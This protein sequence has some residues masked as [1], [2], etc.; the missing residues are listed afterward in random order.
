MM[1]PRICFY[2][3][4]ITECEESRSNAA[5][6]EKAHTVRFFIYQKIKAD[7]FFIQLLINARRSLLG[8]PVA[9]KSALHV[10]IFKFCADG[11][12]FGGAFFAM[13]SFM[14]ALRSAPFMDAE[15]FLHMVRAS[16]RVLAAAAEVETSAS[17]SG[18]AMAKAINTFFI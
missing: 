17:D 12:F 18:K 10:F 5:L 13:Q 7:H 2:K 3:S 8:L 14:K 1:A 11:A 4:S 9:L 15:S 16:V 6:N